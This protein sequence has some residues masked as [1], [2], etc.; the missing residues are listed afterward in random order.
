MSDHDAS[1]DPIICASRWIEWWERSGP[2]WPLVRLS[3][4]DESSQEVTG[5]ALVV[6]VGFP[7]DNPFKSGSSSWCVGIYA[8]QLCTNGHAMFPALHRLIVPLRRTRDVI[9]LTVERVVL[10]GF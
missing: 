6:A 7:S 3:A 10:C 1:E 4:T 5:S 2:K 9:S 8:A